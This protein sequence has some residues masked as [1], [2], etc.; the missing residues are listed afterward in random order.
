MTV[1]T[2]LKLRIAPDRFARLKRHALLK[3]H[4]VARP[5][6]RRLYSIY[7][8]TPILELHKSGMALRLRHA[9]Q[10]WLQTLKG[11][12]SVEA[13]L[14]QRN[15][16]EV[17]VNG[18]AL[19]FSLLS[20]KAGLEK[21]TW[22]EYLPLSLRKK[23]QPVFVTDFSRTSRMLNFQGAEVELCMDHGEISIRQR[24][25]P[26]CELEL[27]LKSGEPRQ[28]FG[29]AL[30]ILEVV[31]FELEMVSKAEYGYRLLSGQSGDLVKGEVAHDLRVQLVGMR[32][33][34]NKFN[35]QSMLLK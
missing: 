9:G 24:S 12:G 14:H 10:Q 27:E 19:D 8:D 30:A 7:F 29:L 22:D 1:E 13:G 17:P 16:W 33:S 20:K 26:I 15:E 6:K 35:V 2:E 3:M 32:D 31:P 5:V 23:L 11:G 25:I 34:I 28:L 4:A 18:P 21:A